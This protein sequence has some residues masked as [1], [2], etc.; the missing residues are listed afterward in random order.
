MR[1][2]LYAPDMWVSLGHSNGQVFVTMPTR[3]DA[4]VDRRLAAGRGR[5]RPIANGDPQPTRRSLVGAAGGTGED[6]M[7]ALRSLSP[8]ELH[9]DVPL[10]VGVSRSVGR[11]VPAWRQQVRSNT[12]SSS[13]V[14][15]A[16]ACFGLYRGQWR[17]RAFERLEADRIERAP[18]ER[19]AARARPAGAPTSACGTG[20]CGKTASSTTT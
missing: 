7:T 12:R 18:Q 19:R 14:L 5:R 3:L 20:I 8:P 2:V 16:A 13:V 9:M 6:R 10:V 15:S 11:G 1:S 17:R 4:R